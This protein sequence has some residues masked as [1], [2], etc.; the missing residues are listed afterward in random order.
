M[1][2]DLIPDVALAVTEAAANAVRHSGCEHFDVQ[3][4]V[5]GGTLVIEVTD[6]GRGR[7]DP[8]PGLGLGTGIIR[9]LAQAVEFEETRPGT[10]VTMRFDRHSAPVDVPR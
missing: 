9:T 3:G 5:S 2:K 7:G 10:R 1:R 4:W 8:E 6:N